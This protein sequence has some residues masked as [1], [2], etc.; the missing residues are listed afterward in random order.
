[1]GVKLNIDGKPVEAEPGATVL[2]AAR[3]VGIEI[4]TLCHGQGLEPVG[5]CF[6]C[7]VEVE[8]RSRLVPSCVCQV[9]E[10][11]VVRTRTEQVASARRSALELLL[12]DHAGDCVAPCVRA[13]PAGMDI[14]RMNALLAEKRFEE[15]GRVARERI[16]FPAVLGWI[17]PAYC[18]RVC[19][20]RRLDEAVSICQLKRIAGEALLE[21]APRGAPKR[22]RSLGKRVA[23]V[24]GGP[25]GMAASV[26]LSLAGA[27]VVLYDRRERLGGRLSSSI[28]CFR[29]PRAVLNGEIEHL[30]RLGVEI[31]LGKAL[32]QDLSLERLETEYD[33]VLLALGA[34]GSSPGMSAPKEPDW[35]AEAILERA[36]EGTLGEM[37]GKVFVA[38]G[39]NEA[40]DAARVC[41]R[42]GADEVFLVWKETRSSMSCFKE[43]LEEALAEGIQLLEETASEEMPPEGAWIEA[44]ERSVDKAFL[45]EMGLSLS[46]RGIEADRKTL[47]TRRPGVFAAGEL[48]T[49]PSSAIRCVASG[50]RA[51]QSILSLLTAGQAAEGSSFHSVL[52][53]LTEEDVEAWRSVAHA[54]PRNDLATSGKEETVDEAK[55]CLQCSCPAE[56]DCRL[57]ELSA[58]YR[59]RQNRFQGER[60]GLRWDLSHEQVAFD[61]GK[62]ILCGLCVRTAQKLGAEPGLTFLGRGFRSRVSVRFGK[63]VKEGLGRWAVQCARA[64]P[65]GALSVRK[66]T[67]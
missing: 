53:R 41:L 25:A 36:A 34:W 20:R 66:G 2:E 47:E 8:G 9:E 22:A 23:V 58:I 19:H 35:T 39:G 28:P 57:R 45:E 3:R 1:M 43:R 26:V 44:P 11:M 67:R 33:A 38:G 56:N 14:P 10:G 12:S 37:G 4:P 46:S 32:G 50:Q 40:V 63:A 65:T 55:R 64:C 15:A 29:L 54:S 62:C 51:A 49:G 61:A 52:G 17:C 59:A 7:V 16:P 18:E 13:C 21:E 60:R 30:S 31:D 24:G 48:A 6:L 42:L 5:S 27:E